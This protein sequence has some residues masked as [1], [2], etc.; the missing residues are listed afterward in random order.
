ML[1]RLLLP[2]ALLL[3]PPAL[4]QEQCLVGAW[5]LKG[6][7]TLDI[8]SL[9]QGALR[10]RKFDGT[11][12]KLFGM[13]SART[14]HSMLGWTGDLDGHRISGPDCDKGWITFDDAEARRVPLDIEDTVFESAGPAEEVAKL[15]GRLV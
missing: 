15:A 9:Q 7:M 5:K 6:G 8:S 10:W 1:H 4:A 11:T 3:A 14:W 2:L 13:E 12:G